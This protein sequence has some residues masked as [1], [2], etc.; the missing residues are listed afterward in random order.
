M[1][2]EMQVRLIRQ[3][4]TRVRRVTVRREARM[5]ETE[6]VAVVVR[7][8]MEAVAVHLV[9]ETELVVHLEHLEHPEQEVRLTAQISS[10]SVPAAHHCPQTA[11]HTIPPVPHTLVPAVSCPSLVIMMM[12]WLEV[13]A[14]ASQPV[15][16]TVQVEVQEAVGMEVMEEEVRAGA[17]EMER[18]VVVGQVVVLVME[19]V[20]GLEVAPEEVP[21]MAVAMA[22]PTGSCRIQTL[23]VP[24]PHCTGQMQTTLLPS[25]RMSPSFFARYAIVNSVRESGKLTA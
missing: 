18:A 11:A 2:V 15:A 17:E 7:R 19:R 23:Q 21:A 5:E 25:Q 22:G 10:L 12:F 20:G 9:R 6:R 24:V 16:G 4:Q 3:E 8:V 13:T 14:S 1:P